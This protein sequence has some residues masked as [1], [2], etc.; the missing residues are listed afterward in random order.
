MLQ[1]AV[2]TEV[3]NFIQSC[4]DRK[5]ENGHRLVVKNG[6]YDARDILT[7]I[8]KIPIQLPRVDDH[9]QRQIT[10][11]EGFRS[12]ILPKYI[13]HSP[14][15]DNMIALLYLMGISTKDFPTALSSIL[16]DQALNLSSATVV[17]LKEQWIKEYET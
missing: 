6:H 3:E 12:A 15:L 9:K 2:E 11:V 7:S 16:G 14:S 8:G 17:R 5:D 4:Q 13:R 1:Y 10:G